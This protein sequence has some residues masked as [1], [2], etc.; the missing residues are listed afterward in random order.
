MRLVPLGACHDGKCGRLLHRSRL[1]RCSA[2]KKMY[3]CSAECQLHHWRHGGHKEGCKDI[4]EM[5]AAFAPDAH[6]GGD[7]VA[8]A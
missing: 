3:Y 2:C 5:N 6:Q 4:Q 1:K 8:A 7:E